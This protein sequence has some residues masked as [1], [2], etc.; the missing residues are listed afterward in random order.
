MVT[1]GNRFTPQGK[2][3][4]LAKIIT[5]EELT[6]DEMDNIYLS[7]KVVLVMMSVRLA[8]QS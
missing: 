2:I 1:E 8:C 6:Q 7:T 3:R 4:S 5:G